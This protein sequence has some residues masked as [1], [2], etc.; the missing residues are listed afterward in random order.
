MKM[1]RI[2]VV[3]TLASCVLGQLQAQSSH[4]HNNNSNGDQGQT[5]TPGQFDY[6]LLTLSWAPEFC[7]GH[8]DSPEC[9]GKHFGFVVH[10][11][12]PQFTSGGW[13]QTCST[14]PGLADPSAMTDI[15]PDPS[16]VAHEWAKHGTCS[17]LDADGYFK[18]VRQAFTSIHVPAKF[19]AP[20]EQFLIT[21]AD[22]KD[23]FV[24]ANPQ[25]NRE[26]M[27]V[28]CGNNYLTAVSVCM[29]KDL[30]AVACQNLKDCRGN[31]IKVPPVQ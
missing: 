2:F 9:Q 26:D 8:G 30:K 5:G 10:G 1:I 6:Y 15:M 13:P 14:G 3:L 7:H 12:W 20:A 4:H 17:G 27:T 16:L 25:L 23:A 22:V 29:G 19:S 11:L 18:A 21:P 31:K 24:E 28:S